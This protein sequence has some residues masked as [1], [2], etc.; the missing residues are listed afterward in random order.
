MQS[1]LVVY[2][3]FFCAEDGRHIK[4]KLNIFLCQKVAQLVSL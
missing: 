1:K 2:E 4:I 3:L